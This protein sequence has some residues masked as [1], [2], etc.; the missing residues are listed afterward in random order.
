[1]NALIDIISKVLRGKDQ[2]NFSGVSIEIPNSKNGDLQEY[3]LEYCGEKSGSG[4]Y[5]NSH[6]AHGDAAEENVP[7]D[8]EWHARAEHPNKRIAEIILYGYYDYNWI[9]VRNETSMAHRT[10]AYYPVHDSEISA[11]K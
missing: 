7:D 11:D 1:M 6:G 2:H 4:I 9:L 5:G 8:Y 10:A 3:S